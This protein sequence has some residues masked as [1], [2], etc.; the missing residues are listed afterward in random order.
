M[1][2]ALNIGKPFDISSMA[3]KLSGLTV[4]EAMELVRLLEKQ[5]DVSATAVP[6][7]QQ[8]TIVPVPVQ[9]EQ[10]EFTVMLTGLISAD[11]KISVI[12]EIRSITQLGLKEAKEF[13]E[14]APHM[15]RESCNKAMADE[16]KTQLET[17]GGVIE[18][19]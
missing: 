8:Q 19:K 4:M 16:L 5:W 1:S 15:V 9:E 11:K 10:T 14:T 6:A 3:D 18:I 2:A 7:V 17:A 13:V 12:K